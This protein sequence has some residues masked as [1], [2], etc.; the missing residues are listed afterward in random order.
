MRVCAFYF[1]LYESFQ[2][3][4]E[5]FSKLTRDPR[6]GMYRGWVNDASFGPSWNIVQ[7][8]TKYDQITEKRRKMVKGR[9]KQVGGQRVAFDPKCNLG[10]LSLNGRVRCIKWW[11]SAKKAHNLIYFADIFWVILRTEKYFEDAPRYARKEEGNIH[12]HTTWTP[13]LLQAT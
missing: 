9:R 7:L 11:K 5:F 6:G 8:C 13:R 12:G 4:K 2:T 3:W 1:V 10:L